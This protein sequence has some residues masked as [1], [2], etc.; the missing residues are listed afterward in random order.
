M[1]AL[2]R[3]AAGLGMAGVRLETGTRQ[4]EALALYAALGYRPIAGY[5]YWRDSPLNRSFEKILPP[6][7]ARA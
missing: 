3:T 4:P 5:G 1:R 7:P 6:A 2:E